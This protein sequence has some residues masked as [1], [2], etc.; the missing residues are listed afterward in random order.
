MRVVLL[1]DADCVGANQA[2]AGGTDG[3]DKVRGTGQI[4]MDQVSNDFGV[5]VGGEFVTG[6]FKFS[7]QCF[8][9]L[10]DAVMDDSQA[11]GDMRVGITLTGSAMGGPTGVGNAGFTGE[12]LFLGFGGQ[13]S[14]TTG[15]ANAD[16]AIPIENGN[17][18]GVITPV[19]QLTQAFEQYRNN[20]LTRYCNNNAAHEANPSLIKQ[21]GNY[22]GLEQPYLAYLLQLISL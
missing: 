3:G 19:F 8:V 1:D 10:D 18:S 20:R 22:T 9:V 16:Q 12:V 14:H 6:G 2:G 4:L 21:F 11:I 13:I 15:G 7:P 17:A 5:G